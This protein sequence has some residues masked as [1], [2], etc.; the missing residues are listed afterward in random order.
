MAAVAVARFVVVTLANAS[1]VADSLV[2][3]DFR[4]ELSG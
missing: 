3:F 2:T 4:D 1:R